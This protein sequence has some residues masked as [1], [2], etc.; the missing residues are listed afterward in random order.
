M[1]MPLGGLCA[2]LR[3]RLEFPQGGPKLNKSNSVIKAICTRRS[4]RGYQPGPISREQLETIVDCG[5]L[6]PTAFNE[7][8]WEFIVVTEHT[9][10]VEIARI[11]PENCPFMG[12]A[13][14]CIVV[15]GMAN[16]SSVYLDGAAATENI[17]LAAHSMQMGAC[18]IQT[19]D[20]PY[21][22]PIMELLGIPDTH[23]LVSMVSI[24]IQ[25]Q[26]AE[27]MQKRSL[28]EVLH[29]ERF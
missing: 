22:D 13:T 7:Q 1:A 4:V 12:D 8:P 18:W 2:R 25:F 16:N 19:Q 17:L 15:A 3:P 9:T 21:N 6:A 14:A 23:L 10:L 24:G 20:K 5:R 29:W 26:D 27:P 11:A 28:E